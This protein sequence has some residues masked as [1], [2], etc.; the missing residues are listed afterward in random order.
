MKTEKL[1]EILPSKMEVASLFL[2]YDGTIAPQHASR[3]ESEVAAETHEVL[4]Q[5]GE[6]IPIAIVTSKDSSFVVPKTLFA[7][8][9][10]TMCG[11]STQIGQRIFE[12]PLADSRL[13]C[14]HEVLEVAKSSSIRFGFEIEEKHDSRGRT[15]GFCV[16]WRR[17]LNSNLAKRE[18]DLLALR[19][20]ALSLA[21]LKFEDN[22]FYDVY[23]T[24][25]DKGEAVRKLRKAL[26]LKGG[27][28]FLGDSQMDN[29]AF[30]AS[31]VSVA[32][33]NLETRLNQL[34]ADYSVRYDDASKF[35]EALLANRL[36]FSQDLFGIRPNPW[37]RGA[38]E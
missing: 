30:E 2:D 3:L 18:A 21:V 17:S 37:R 5:I 23:P 4:T 35:L 29:S 10:S 24:F 36:I 38:N 9:W 1:I 13:E 16:D 25:V 26:A 7:V 34:V 19:C 22:P 15:V 20:K 14:L 6:K 27:V 11:L 32:V 31:D 33:V 8:A 12:L 28:L